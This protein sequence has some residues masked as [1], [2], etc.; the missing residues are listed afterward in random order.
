MLA[1]FFI[2]LIA[3]Q[4]TAFF[5]TQSFNK[6]IYPDGTLVITHTPQASFPNDWTYC[7]IGENQIDVRVMFYNYEGDSSLLTHIDEQ[8]AEADIHIDW[9]FTFVN[10]SDQVYFDFEFEAKVGELQD[11]VG[12]DIVLVFADLVPPKDSVYDN[13]GGYARVQNQVA[14]VFTPQLATEQYI[15][16]LGLHELSH[17][18]G[19]WHSTDSSDVMYP[20]YSGGNNDFTAETIDALYDLHH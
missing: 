14:I 10:E 19:Y 3:P 1:T 9:G 16:S 8:L 12:A 20:T 4:T 2:I 18:L 7:Y 17:C 13:L 15:S 11:R 6:S 5:L